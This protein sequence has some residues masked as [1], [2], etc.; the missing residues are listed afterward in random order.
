MFISCFTP[1]LSL[2]EMAEHPQVAER[3][4]VIKTENFLGSGKTMYIP[5]NPVKLSETPGEIRLTFPDIGEHTREILQEIGYT[6]EEISR[7]KELGIVR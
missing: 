6:P 1:V 7:F 3:Q 2:Q 5:G 4:M